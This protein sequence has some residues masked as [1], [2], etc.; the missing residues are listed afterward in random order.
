MIFSFKAIKVGG[1]YEDFIAPDLDGVE[2]QLSNLKEGKI[3]VLDLWA[4]WCRP[5]LQKSRELIPIYKDYHGD[6][7][8]IVGVAR[9]FKHTKNLERVL[10][11][12]KY[13]WLNL[14]E[15]DDQR[16]IWLKYKIPFSGG[17]IFL[18]DRE[19]QILAINPTAEEVRRILEEKGISKVRK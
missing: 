12:E 17:G 13:P 16:E 18:I 1:V 4:S 8:T 19:G 14:L 5:C 15:L 3:L 11:R 9:E 7:F 10:A 2:Y 6:D